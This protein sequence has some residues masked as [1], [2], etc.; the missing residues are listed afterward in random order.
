MKGRKGRLNQRI[1]AIMMAV[2]MM[3]SII[4]SSYPAAAAPSDN[5][6]TVVVSNNGSPVVNASVSYQVVLASDESQVIS[7]NTVPTDN[8]GYAVIIGQEQC[9]DEYKLYATITKDNFENGSVDGGTITTGNESFDVSLTK[10]KADSGMVKAASGLVYNTGNQNLVSFEGD[11]GR[12][13]VEYKLDGVST[14][15]SI[16]QGKN[17]GDY[18]VYY[19]ITDNTGALDPVDNTITVN[20][21]KKPLDITVTPPTNLMYSGNEQTL[22]P[23]NCISGVQ[24][25]DVVSFSE[26]GTSYSGTSPKGKDAGDYTVYVK[27]DRND[28][29]YEVFNKS[30]TVSISKQK[31]NFKFEL[32]NEDGVILQPKATLE[33]DNQRVENFNNPHYYELLFTDL[34]SLSEG[35][36]DYKVDCVKESE[37]DPFASI[38]EDGKLK[39]TDSGKVSITVTLHG[40]GKNI[41]DEV[42]VYSLEVSAVKLIYFSEDKNYV[43][44]SNNNVASIQQISTIPSTIDKKRIG[45]VTYSMEGADN[46]GLGIVANSGKITVT[47]YEKLCSAVD[48]AENKKLAVTVKAKKARNWRY[49][50]EDE[51]SYILNISYASAPTGDFELDGT[52]GDAGWYTSDVKISISDY[53]VA[54]KINSGATGFTDT[55]TVTED[56]E[57]SGE[58]SVKLYLQDTREDTEGQITAQKTV[59]DFKIDKTKPVIAYSLDKENE[60]TKSITFTV[61]EKNFDSQRITISQI[62]SDTFVSRDIN[63]KEVSLDLEYMLRNGKWEKGE[64]D[65][66]TLT[67]K[68][69]DDLV[70]AIYSFDI[71]CKDEAGNDADTCSVEEFIVDYSGPYIDPDV[72]VT[73]STPLNKTILSNI[74]LGFYNPTVKITFTAYDAI[75][76]VK[77][78][79]WGYKRESGAS[80]INL[81]KYTDKTVAAV[82]DKTD[83]S[84]YTATIELPLSE[85]KQLRGSISFKATDNKQNTS[86]EYDDSKKN[87]F[88]VD[89]ISPTSSI[90]YSDASKVVGNKSLYNKDLVVTLTV[91]EANFFA[92]DVDFRV[93]KDGAPYTFG[94]IWTDNKDKHTAELTIPALPDH[95]NDGVYVFMVDYKDRSNNKM[96]S[97]T[98]SPKEYII[99]TT[100]PSISVSYSNTEPANTMEDADGNSRQYF[101]GDQI[102][103]I[104]ITE[105]NFDEN[106]VDFGIL[107]KDVQGTEL[108]VDSYISKDGWHSESGDRHV[109]YITYPG[110][111]NYTFDVDYTDQAT[112]KMENYNPDYFTVDKT[113]PTNLYVTYSTSVLDTVLQNISF[114]F[115]NAKTTVTITAEDATSPVNKFKYEY[116]KASGVSAV[117]AELLNQAIDNASITYSNNNKTATATFEIPQGVLT[118]SNQFN[119][120]VDFSAIDR[121]DN[122]SSTHQESKR[123]VVDNI[124]PNA[125][126]S[127]NNPVNVDGGISYFDDSITATVTINEANFYAEDVQISVT[128]DGGN[129]PVSAAWSNNSVDTHVGTFNMTEDGEYKVNITYTDKSR[130]SMANYSSETMIIDTDKDAVDPIIRI[131]GKDDIDGTAY[132]DK[133][134]PSVEFEDDNLDDYEISLVRTRMDEKNLDVNDLYIKDHVK[135]SDT[136]GEG[137]FDE[138]KKIQDNDGIYTLSVKMSDK[139]GHERS[140]EATFTVNRYGSV[141]VFSDYLVDLIADGGKYVQAVDEDL[142]ISEYNPDKLVEKSLNIEISADGKPVEDRLED[143]VTPEINDKVTTGNSGWYQYDYTIDKGNFAKD[144]VYKMVVSSKDKTGNSPENT[145][146]E[147]KTILFR[148]DSTPPEISSISGLEDKIINATDVDVNYTVYDAIGL[149]SL[150]VYHDGEE[151][152]NITDFSEDANNYSGT[153]SLKESSSEQKVRIV[154]EDLAGNITDTASKDFNSAY[155]F[156]ESVTVSTN[157][158]VR[159]FANKPLF[160][161]S[162]GGF[163]VLIGAIVGF[164]ALAKRRKEER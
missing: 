143:K 88:V 107:A 13:S 120:T 61:T 133:C 64:G 123:I 76:G 92:D 18:E 156:N 111:A 60:N 81:D 46:T 116:V 145:N 16:P 57:Y 2:I 104:T 118:N 128:K 44:S 147:D 39:F 151:V 1:L 137:E 68:A 14:G 6:V 146:Y 5:A 77:D 142:I 56:K 131:N 40:D 149:K 110:D 82:Q 33:F 59:Q 51:A 103:T 17:A 36:V 93:T 8:N 158:F 136:K 23:N 26:D 163:I 63:G 127:Y 28:S 132:K 130:N 7:S 94:Y 98:S 74:T 70:D 106:E 15:S 100:P 38:T 12:Y 29:N 160:Y 141:Y 89:T 126:V 121:A 73:Y 21:A 150:K 84:K 75:T 91:E 34:T 139:A 78:F 83:K 159:W 162:I 27:V 35:K 138:F 49:N 102:A 25:G 90:E 45:T 3:I 164:I 54:D 129:Y 117:N 115:Y 50:F 69:K 43:I 135:V 79:T 20:I 4:S 47:D 101:N 148:V 85:A 108:N 72:A 41:D 112:N 134:V 119:G 144:G 11:P 9:T 80:D 161:G 66:H 125:N 105:R 19:K 58:N 67:L 30:Y 153:I 124:A 53:K 152:E 97:Y 122:E 114:G 10:K 99:D 32:K 113:A 155:D 154:V 65:K 48:K 37:E 62:D 140:S 52:L 24:A 22:L 55:Y 86:Y 71:D 31:Q 42:K 109:M 95:S 96:T 157:F 87:V